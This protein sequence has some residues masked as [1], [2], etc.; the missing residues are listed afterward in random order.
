MPIT[1]S[2]RW[3]HSNCYSAESACEHCAGTIHH[4]SWCITQ[5]SAVQYAYEIVARPMRL[6]ADDSLR[7]HSLGVRWQI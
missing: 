7:L 1:E 2:T 3:Y 4:E 6:T 5:N